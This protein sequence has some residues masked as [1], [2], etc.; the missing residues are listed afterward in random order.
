MS[1]ILTNSL[2]NSYML[3]HLHLESNLWIE[4]GWFAH[5]IRVLF[6]KW[7]EKS[8][9]LTVVGGPVEGVM[10]VLAN[11]LVC[12]F[13]MSVT[14]MHVGRCIYSVDDVDEFR[15]LIRNLC[16]PCV[17]NLAA[18]A[19]PSTH[20]SRNFVRNCGPCISGCM[21]G[22]RNSQ[23]IRTTP[24]I[25]PTKQLKEGWMLVELGSH[26]FLRNITCYKYLMP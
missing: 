11:G 7:L 8:C 6:N 2:T 21:P 3:P 15:R 1:D 19:A 20:T 9:P 18:R 24:S 22:L 16:V 26:I 17:Q 10:E 13:W 14:Q 25:R 12:P 4:D 5:L 23:Q